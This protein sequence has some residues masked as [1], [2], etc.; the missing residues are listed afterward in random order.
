MVKIFCNSITFF[1]MVLFTQAQI[2]PNTNS[3]STPTQLISPVPAAYS[4]NV[5]VNFLRTLVPQMPITNVNEVVNNTNVSQVQQTTQYFD[6]LGRPLQT[7]AKKMSGGQKDIVSM[8]VYDDFGRETQT[9]LPYVQTTGGSITNN[10][11]FKVDPFANQASFLQT[12]YLGEQVFYNQTILEASPLNRPLKTMAAGNSWAGNNRGV[13]IGYEINVANE[14]RLWDIAYVNGAIP[15]TTSSYNAGE[16]YRNITTDEH[17]KHVIEYKDKEGKVVLKKVQIENAVTT[18]SHT[19]WL[20]T[21]YIYDD[22]GLLRFVIPPVA[23]EKLAVNGWDLSHAALTNAV[24]ELCFRYEYDD[25]NRMI[26]K[27]VPGA[28]EVYMIYDKRDRLVFTQDGN[29]RGKSPNWWLYTLYDALDRPLQTGILQSNQTRVQLQDYVTSNTGGG[30]ITDLPGINNLGGSPADLVYTQRTPQ[31]AAYQASNS[32]TFQSGF[33]STIGEEFVAEIVTSIGLT[34]STTISVL[35]N[36][37]PTGYT[38]IPLTK[39]FYDNYTAT[40]KT[41][42][43]VS[44][45]NLDAGT[46]TYPE[47]LPTTASTN[48]KGMVTSTQVRVLENPNSPATGRWLETTIFYDEKGRAI[49]SNADNYKGGNDVITSLY[50]FSGK[51]LSTY[52]VHNNASGGINNFGIRTSMEY[53]HAGRLLSIKKRTNN[54]DDR[55]I[56]RNTYNEL[57]QLQ[58]KEL[59]QKRNEIGSSPQFSS[60]PLEIDNYTYNIRGWLK[61][62]NWN[63][64]NTGTS[65]QTSINSDKWFAYDL[66]YD[67]GFNTPSSGVAGGGYFNG[68][69]AGQRW[70]SAGDMQERCFGYAYDNANRLLIADFTQNNGSTTSPVWSN[71]LT[72][73]NGGLIDFS[74]KMGDGIN[75]NTAYDANG[76]IL[77]MQQKGMHT[78]NNSQLIDN[79]KYKYYNNSNKLQNV[80]DLNNEATTKLGDFRTATTHT[81]YGVKNVINNQS[82]YDINVN[83]NTVAS[84]YDYGYDVNGNMIADLNKGIQ[85]NTGIDQTAGGAIEYN[86]LNLPYKITIPNKGTITYIYDATGNKLEKII[87]EDA[88]TT[89]PPNTPSTTT[90]TSYLGAFIYNNNS[91]QFIN[92]EEG[93]LRYIPPSAPSGTPPQT[94]APE[95]YYDY[96]LKDHLGNVRA[97]LTDERKQDVYPAATLEEGAT[98]IEGQYYDINTANIANAPSNLP[99]N[100]P[101][102][103]GIYNNNPNSNTTANSQKMYKLNGSTPVKTGLGITL[104]VMAGDVVNIFGKSYWFDNATSIDNNNPLST[105]LNNLLTTFS[106]SNAVTTGVHGGAGITAGVLQSNP[107]TAGALTSFL[108]GVPTPAGNTPKANIYWVLFDE[109]FT[110][111]ASNAEPVDAGNVVKNYAMTA[112]VTKNGY[113]YVFCGNESNKDVFFDNL[114]LVHNKSALLE[115][116]HYYPFGLTMSGVSSKAVNNILKNKEKNFQS[117][118]FDDDLN[119]N[120]VQFKWRNHDVQIGKFIEIDPLAEDYVYNSIYAFSENKVTNH[121]ELEGLEAVPVGSPQGYLMEGFR[122]IFQAAGNLFS[123]KAEVHLNKEVEVKTEV[124]TPAGTVEN[125]TT[126]TLV[127]NKVEFKTNFGDYFKYGGGK[128]FEFSAGSSTMSN[129]ENTTSATLK[130]NGAPIKVSTKKTAD[131]NGISQTTSI[132]AGASVDIGKKGSIG[133]STTG[134]ITQQ[135]TGSNAGQKFFGFKASVDATFVSKSTSIINTPTV[136]S[137][138]NTQTSVGGSFTQQYNFLFPWLK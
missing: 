41:Y 47:A 48:T 51:I 39:T 63:Y 17:G 59:G 130:T 93:R 37:I 22:F 4:N 83:N 131:E 77:Q 126:T 137:S 31:I 129:T 121:I 16:L 8:H 26:L 38:T 110:F 105:V 56:V 35:D 30:I 13:S 52:A 54:E 36:P 29:M 104:K 5:N 50:D 102:N 116:T 18:T 114:Q 86:H 62:V 40:S 11:L 94:T 106:S 75:Y 125:T 67:W 111:I 123:F 66:S 42:A 44:N 127:E 73:N 84:I 108:N 7:V 46:G 89:A 6:G 120:W 100:Y 33:E 92:H 10:G 109:H 34:S 45:T 97:V 115:E 61:G 81:Q 58:T 3:V 49:Q 55:I 60:D 135:L 107:A 15:T 112:N 14:V 90:T 64:Q 68:N 57:G 12:Q 76:N 136:K 78:F 95:Y 118:R 138:I 88:P 117:Q 91:L 2:I 82:Q 79:L 65:A 23:V 69:I 103:N 96:M 20:C 124:K 85:G 43:T 1:L 71:N 74:V 72:P 128:I 19:G 87:K 32:I 21:Y 70:Q 113:L 28:G 99:I 9:Y 134:F 119:L 53:D 122:Q 24:N 25:R 98:A 101:N 133:I 132:G 80:I 27:K